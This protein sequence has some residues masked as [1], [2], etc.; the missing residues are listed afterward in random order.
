MPQCL[1]DPQLV[2][3]WAAQLCRILLDVAADCSLPHYI[4]LCHGYKIRYS[5]SNLQRVRTHDRTLPPLPAEAISELPTSA[6]YDFDTL[7]VD[8]Y[9]ARRWM[10]ML[11]NIVSAKLSGI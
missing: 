8:G 10:Y 6:I 5:M 11:G 1:I 3:P 7:H 4:V 9:T 2:N